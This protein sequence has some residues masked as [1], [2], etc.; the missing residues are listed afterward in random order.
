MDEHLKNP[1]ADEQAN[2]Y[3]VQPFV[4]EEIET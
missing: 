1:V 2:A 3:E 4:L